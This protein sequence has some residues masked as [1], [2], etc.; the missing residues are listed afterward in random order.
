MN[1]QVQATSVREAHA[2]PIFGAGRPFAEHFGQ[3]HVGDFFEV[4]CKFSEKSPK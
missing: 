3:R 2:G 4:G 1:F